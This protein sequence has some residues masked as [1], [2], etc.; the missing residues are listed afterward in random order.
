MYVCRYVNFNNEWY[1]LR[2]ANAS[3]RCFAFVQKLLEEVKRYINVDSHY[4]RGAEWQ[5]PISDGLM[6][7]LQR[8]KQLQM[9]CS[10]TV[11][12]EYIKAQTVV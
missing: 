10:Q 7:N 11:G 9:A 12:A 8:L 2:C 3:R 6:N 1:K 4:R 5:K